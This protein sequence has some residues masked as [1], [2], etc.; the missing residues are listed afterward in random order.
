MEF[1]HLHL[2]STET[3]GAPASRRHCAARPPKADCPRKAKRMSPL[4]GSNRIST[5]LP[6]AY[7]VGYDFV[8]PPALSKVRSDKGLHARSRA[9][10]QQCFSTRFTVRSG[11]GP[12]YK[13]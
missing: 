7:A 3:K 6:T 1:T 5:P 13:R 11:G 4:R 2:H 8:A 9:R 12:R 10:I